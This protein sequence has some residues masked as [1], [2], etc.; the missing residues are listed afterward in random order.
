MIKELK[1]ESV[2]SRIEPSKLA[3]LEEIA[4]SKG[5]TVSAILQD[6][7]DAFIKKEDIQQAVSSIASSPDSIASSPDSIDLILKRKDLII[8]VL[9]DALSDRK[10][11]ATWQTT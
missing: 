9:A 5:E 8:D 11:G 10:R 2:T 7:I 3:K 4:E 1:S 6:L